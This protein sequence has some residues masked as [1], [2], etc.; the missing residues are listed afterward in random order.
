MSVQRLYG[1]VTDW[2]P[3]WLNEWRKK[4][5]LYLKHA[6]TSM[7]RL[8]QEG[9]ETLQ[10]WIQTVYSY[11]QRCTDVAVKCL[12]GS[13]SIV[14]QSLNIMFI[15]SG[16]RRCLRLWVIF[17]PVCSAEAF[18]QLFHVRTKGSDAVEHP[19]NLIE[20]TLNVSSCC[21]KL[22]ESL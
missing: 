13:V 12:A 15:K 11:T 4:N 18:L 20:F 7:P 16:K 2:F 1:W 10:A 21:L 3:A 5:G 6:L 19:K 17:G 8:A 14:M 9:D 22:L